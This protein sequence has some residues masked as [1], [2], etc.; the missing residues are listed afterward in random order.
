M[1]TS[2]MSIMFDDLNE[3]AQKEYIETFGD[4]NNLDNNPIAIIEHED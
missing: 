1:S 4:D 3:D 2:T